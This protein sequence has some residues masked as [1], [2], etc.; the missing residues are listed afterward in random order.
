MSN[1]PACRLQSLHPRLSIVR[2]GS[3][4]TGFATIEEPRFPARKPV[5]SQSTPGRVV[6][7]YP[8]SFDPIT[9]GHLDLI[10]RARRVTDKLIVAVLQNEGKQALFSMEERVD[11]LR[12]VLRPYPDV[13]VDSF[14]GLLVEYAVAK[15]ASV[16]MRGIRAVSDYEYELQMALMNRRLRPEIETLFLMSGEAYS[17]VSSRLVKEVIALGGNIEG[18]VPGP[19][20]ERLKRRLQGQRL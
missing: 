9:N 8:G 5:S 16:I 20:E 17:F 15:G 10:S 3:K 19:V 12:E 7:I 2:S 6:A 11:M 1:R 18:L 4:S 14:S 13:E